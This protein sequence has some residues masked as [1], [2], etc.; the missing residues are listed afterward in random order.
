MWY[1]FAQNRL[2]SSLHKAL[3]V[4][5]LHGVATQRFTSFRCRIDRA[6]AKFFCPFSW[7]PKR[8]FTGQRTRYFFYLPPTGGRVDRN[9][10]TTARARKIFPVPGMGRPA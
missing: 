9:R 3:L 6:G 10:L 5:A 7:R 1:E 4:P 2:L 8:F